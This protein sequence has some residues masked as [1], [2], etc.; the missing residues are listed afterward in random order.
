MDECEAESGVE[1]GD[2]AGGVEGGKGVG[3]GG[4]VTVL[5]VDY[6]AL[7]D[8]SSVGKKQKEN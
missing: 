7:V 8:G 1:A 3:E 5:V 2:A 6:G 4:S